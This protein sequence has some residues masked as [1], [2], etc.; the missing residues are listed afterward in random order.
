MRIRRSRT[1]G[2]RRAA[3]CGLAAVLT[4]SIAHG[5]TLTASRLADLSLQQLAELPV[6]SVTGRPESL[7]SAG[8]WAVGAHGSNNTVADKLLVLI[9]GRSI[10]SSLFADVFRDFH[11]VML[12]GK[13]HSGPRC[14]AVSSHF[15]R[16]LFLGVVGQP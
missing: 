10:H 3:A 2:V 1:T 12:E 11:E 4:A 16:R 14:A 6:T 7:R 9:D 8:Q 15:G 13:S 5:Q